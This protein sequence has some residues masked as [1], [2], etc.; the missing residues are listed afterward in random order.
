LENNGLGYAVNPNLRVCDTYSGE[1]DIYKGPMPNIFSYRKWMNAA[2]H[3]PN[4]VV[5][6]LP[7]NRRK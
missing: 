1:L 7:L 6:V 3:C 5:L 4:I 2:G